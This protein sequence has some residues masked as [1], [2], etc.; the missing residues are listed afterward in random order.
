MWS[1]IRACLLVY[2]N[3]VPSSVSVSDH[4]TAHFWSLAVEEHFY[5]LFPLILLPLGLRRATWSLPML[6]LAVAVWRVFDSK[7]HITG[8][9]YLTVK[10]NS[11]T[12]HRLDG[13]I[14]GCWLA[15][16]LWRFRQ[17]LKP[18]VIR[19]SG[20]IAAAVVVQGVVSKS[21]LHTYLVA[22]FF[23][24][25][26]LPIILAATM[27][28]PGDPLSRAL[29]W[30]PVRWLG[31]LSYSLYL[32]QQ[33]F[34]VMHVNRKVPMLQPLQDFP[35]NL[36]ALLICATASYYIL[37]RP[38]TRL[39]HRLARPVNAGRAEHPVPSPT[40]PVPALGVAIG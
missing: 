5:F 15:V 9:L 1:D 28:S 23:P 33:I 11:R 20:V 13:L 10:S 8:D 36:I 37:E 40:Q 18:W 12:D 22:L 30:G 26:F 27:L 38:L 7:Y 25:A 35:Y 17:R 21:I 2:R 6:A 32:W 34:F 31:R 16:L 3:Y 24:G 4:Y 39:G 14:W 19:G 29:E